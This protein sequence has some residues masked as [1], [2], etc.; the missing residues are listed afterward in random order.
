MSKL[1]LAAGV[2]RRYTN[3]SL[4]STCIT[5]LDESG[6]AIRDICNVTG[7]RNEKSI[8]TYIGRPNDAKKQKLSDALSTSIGY[9]P[10]PPPS[11]SQLSGKDKPSTSRGGDET[12]QKEKPSTVSTPP[13]TQ[14]P[15]LSQPPNFD[16]ELPLSNSQ[17][18]TLEQLRVGLVQR[19]QP[20]AHPQPHTAAVPTTTVS[21]NHGAFYR[22]H[23]QT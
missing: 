22:L 9:A 7:H 5:L 3:H 10:N 13:T 19:A 18:E 21:S 17:M 20:Q 23:D 8:R 1:S 11:T 6:F 4:R 15:E 14:S 2:S 16:I 12:A